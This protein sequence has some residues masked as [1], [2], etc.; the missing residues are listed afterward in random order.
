VRES[1]QGHQY[2][3]LLIDRG[4]ERP[5]VSQGDPRSRAGEPG[6]N[7]IKDDGNRGSREGS[8]DP[9]RRPRPPMPSVPAL[10]GRFS[11]PRPFLLGHVPHRV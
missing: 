6:I 10:R 1:P 11:D 5:V 9:G 7:E 2:I 8:D 3:S 4:L